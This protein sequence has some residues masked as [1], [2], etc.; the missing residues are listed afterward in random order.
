MFVTPP[1]PPLISGKSSILLPP[2][3]LV[4]QGVLLPDPPALALGVLLPEP[5][6]VF[7]CAFNASL[8]LLLGRLGNAPPPLARPL[9]PPPVECTLATNG[10]TPLFATTGAADH[11]A[12]PAEALDPC[13]TA[14]ANDPGILGVPDDP[15]PKLGK[16]CFNTTGLLPAPEELEAARSTFSQTAVLAELD[17]LMLFNVPPH[18]PPPV[19]EGN[20]VLSN[21]HSFH[22]RPISSRFS[23]S[24]R[25]IIPFTSV[26]HSSL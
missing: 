24:N 5:N 12:P 13:A 6:R 2:V 10:F 18:S 17:F 20:C 16:C 25:S 14:C 7:L 4:N 21:L 1:P 26:A 3:P 23:P 15:E 11:L 9:P 19:R 22:A 8:S